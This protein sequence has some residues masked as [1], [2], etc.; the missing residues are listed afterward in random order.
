MGLPAVG[1]VIG[2]YLRS[3]RLSPFLNLQYRLAMARICHD[4]TEAGRY[5]LASDTKTVPGAV[6]STV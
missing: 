2:F 5:R 1:G 3:L 6:G 4:A